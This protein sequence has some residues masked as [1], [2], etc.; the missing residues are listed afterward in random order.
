[1]SHNVSLFSFEQFVVIIYADPAGLVQIIFSVDTVFSLAP[2]SVS[3]R[4]LPRSGIQRQRHPQV[5]QAYQ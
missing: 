4:Q 1:M 2:H 3:G 5:H